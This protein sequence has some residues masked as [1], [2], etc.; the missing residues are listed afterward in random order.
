MCAASGIGVRAASALLALTS[1]DFLLA[2]TRLF[3]AKTSARTF[4]PNPSQV[5]G[6]GVIPAKGIFAVTFGLYCRITI[7]SIRMMFLP[8]WTT[9]R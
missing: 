5:H 2:E 9:I 1:S 3:Q 8:A 7:I 4:N 6:S